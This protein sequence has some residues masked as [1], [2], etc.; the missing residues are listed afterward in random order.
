M[1]FTTF[2]PSDLSSGITLTNGNLTA[3]SGGGSPRSVRAVHGKLSGKYY[4]EFTTDTV[5][6]GGAFG[7]MYYTT[8][9]N[10]IAFGGQ[11]AS[12]AIDVVFSGGSIYLNQALDL[13]TS[14][15]FANGNTYGVA[16]D[17]DNALIWFRL[18]PSGNWNN[19]ASYNPATGVGGASFSS[20]AS[21]ALLFYPFAGFYNAGQVTANFGA[22]SF[23][24]TAPG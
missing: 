24:V 12:P 14:F 13:N 17:L 20:L 1:A 22:T 11:G 8:L 15:T 6:S 3:S 18:A 9:L 2:N 19:N 10:S 21:P 16:V 5:G 23:S 4:Y 7:L